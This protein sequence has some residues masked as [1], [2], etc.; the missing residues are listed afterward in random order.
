MPATTGE[1]GRP[2]DPAAG[3]SPSECA[4]R[5]L[6]TLRADDDSAPYRRRLA[7][8]DDAE[9]ER[10]RDDREVA[11]AVWTN[12]YNAG[13]QLLLEERPDLYDARLR[14]LRFFRAD[15]LTVAGTPLSLNEIE[16]GILRG[17]SAVG[18]GYLPRLLSGEFER[19]HRLE[20]LDPRVHFALNC[21]A[22]SC[23][24]IRSYQVDRIDD[25]LE[26]ATRTYLSNT[27]TYDAETAVARVPRL[28]LWYRGDFGGGE[29]IRDLLRQY[30]AV[31]DGAVS[32]L[33]HRSWDWRRQA[34]KFV[35]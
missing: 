8:F 1:D 5:L 16:H 3:C 29:G 30:D 15:C 33:K 24:A 10:V 18:L 26:L 2:D 6:E 13:T 22:G 32:R 35:D 7:T 34:A 28:F 23:P 9:L 20:E 4:R 12:L 21:G 31:P 14:F 25:Q 17:R 11:L 19:R 27:V